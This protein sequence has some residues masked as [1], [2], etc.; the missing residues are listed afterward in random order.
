MLTPALFPSHGS[1]LDDDDEDSEDEYDDD[2]VLSLGS[3]PSGAIGL[4]TSELIDVA[5]G[6]VDGPR[7]LAAD[8]EVSFL[9]HMCHCEPCTPCVCG[10]LPLQSL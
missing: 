2:D 10:T 6:Q 1:L 7:R 9:L 4:R 8:S 5:A 3:G